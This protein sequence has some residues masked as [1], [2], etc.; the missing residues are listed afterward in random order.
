MES[1]VQ[2]VERR[3]LA[4]LRH[5]R[6]ADVLAADLAVA[7]LLPMLNG[8]PM[9]KLVATRAGL[10]ASIH[11]PA[12]LPLPKQPW[13]WTRWKTVTAHIDYQ[14]E[15]GGHRYSVSHALVGTKLE[16]RVGD[17]LVEQHPAR[18]LPHP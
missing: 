6:L 10:F 12:L 15:I 5:R 7:E 11:A 2:V 14:G 1:A 9:Q 8:R 16:A 3:I 4:R 13:S 18:L 17:A